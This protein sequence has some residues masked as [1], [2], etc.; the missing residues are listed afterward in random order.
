[1]NA[2]RAVTSAGAAMVSLALAAGIAG[3]D[4][5]AAPDSEAAVQTETPSTPSATQAPAVSEGVAAQVAMMDKN[6][7]GSIGADEHA[8]GAGNMFATMDADHDGTVTAAEMDAAQAAFKGDKRMSS[9]DKI[10]TIDGNA[11]GTLSR[12][13]HEAGSQ[14]M[15][16]KMDA[17]GDGRLTPAEMQ[18][19]HDKTMGK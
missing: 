19:G 16:A 3:C 15:F 4:R 8:A 11:D 14:A 18:A 1:M 5:H 13:E 7:D 9:A 6:G 17:D 10:K 12:E 2:E